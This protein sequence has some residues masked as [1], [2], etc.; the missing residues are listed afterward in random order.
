MS[1]GDSISY[2]LKKCTPL[3]DPSRNEKTYPAGV[4]KKL[5]WL[6]C[7]VELLQE[8]IIFLIYLFARAI[9]SM[10]NLEIDEK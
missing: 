3:I 4:E 8:G 1:R 5:V 2:N 10:K 6:L 7:K 9:L